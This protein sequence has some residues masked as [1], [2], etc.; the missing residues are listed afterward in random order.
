MKTFVLSTLFSIVASFAFTQDDTVFVRYKNAWEGDENT[1]FVDTF[2]VHQGARP[3]FLV[4]TTILPGTSNQNSGYHYGLSF[5]DVTGSPCRSDEASEIFGPDKILSFDHTDS[6]LII[7]TKIIGNCCHDF[8]CDINVD[9][10]GVLNLIYTGYGEYCACDCCFGLIF[11]FDHDQ[12][13]F[14][15]DKL[16]GIIIN[17]DD[18]TFRKLD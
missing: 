2:P 14:Y 9:T 15:E 8:L 12:G 11:T 1:Y 6:T 4:G 17:G 13:E 5:E 10:N 7:E 18:K 16:T 3:N